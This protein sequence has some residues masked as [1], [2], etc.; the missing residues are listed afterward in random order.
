MVHLD[1]SDFSKDVRED[2]FMGSRDR[3]RTGD[4]L[5]KKLEKELENL[6]KNDV[7]LKKCTTLQKN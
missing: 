2:L 3:L 6:L 4:K 5:S 7:L 1:C